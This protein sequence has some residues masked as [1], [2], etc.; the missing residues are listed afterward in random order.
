MGSGTYCVSDFPQDLTIN[1]KH[2]GGGTTFYDCGASTNQVYVTWTNTLNAIHTLLD[3][4]CRGA[5]GVTGTV[6]IND[7]QVLNGVWGRIQAK[8]NRRASDYVLLTYYGFYDVNSNGVWD[9]GTDINRNDPSLCTVTAA[10]ELIRT[11]NGQC[12]SWADFIHQVLRGQGL[13]AING[14]NNRAVAAEIKV[15]IAF[16]VKNWATSRMSPRNIISFDAGV[17]GSSAVTP[18]PANNEAADAPGVAGQGNSPNPPSEFGNHWI[19]KLN[20]KYYD[21]SY[22]IGPFTD[23]KAYEDAAF[24]GSIETGG[25]G[26]RLKD[27]PANDG[28]PSNHADEINNYTETSF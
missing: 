15:G 16:G 13:E 5:K 9:A 4:G 1:W 14:N 17:D 12:H 27:L 26:Y 18:N 28:D 11:G 8:S 10:S 7:D 24:S 6:G 2:T 21:P 19:D 25:S 3:V 22:G 20:G 23:L